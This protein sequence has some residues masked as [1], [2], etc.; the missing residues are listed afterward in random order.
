MSKLLRNGTFQDSDSEHSVPNI[1]SGFDHHHRYCSTA[2]Y[3][4]GEITA[5]LL[6]VACLLPSS[7]V[8]GETLA[9]SWQKHEISAGADAR[10]YFTYRPASR[11]A[12]EALP[13]VLVF[14]G[15]ESDP[16]GMR[17]MIHAD[18]WAEQFGFL[19]VY[20]EGRQKRWQATKGLGGFSQASADRLF[21]KTLMKDLET[22]PGVDK[23][24]IYAMGYSNGSEMVAM[25]V[26]TMPEAVLAG[27]MVASAIDISACPKAEVPMALVHGAK[28]RLAPF[29]GGGSK[30]IYS[31][32]QTVEHFR[33]ANGSPAL[34]AKVVD[35]PSMRCK[36]FGDQV[37]D[38]VGFDDGHTW[39]GGEVFKADLLGKTNTE[40]SASELF[41]R[42]FSKHQPERVDP[43]M[44]AIAPRRA[45]GLAASR[46]Y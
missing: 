31:H 30:R 23:E 24:R 35:M 13:V 14:H 33:Q 26:C 12:G 6:L 43:R 32:R 38:C 25:L 41:F 29:E 46:T 9:P 45:L 15:F 39:P 4:L 42:F 19:M 40:V 28:D 2:G 44:R 36:A 17:W 18:H 20:P 3:P 27:A 10:V 1:D 16:K 22:L 5:V 21:L 8:A 37:L 7:S 11:S 34:K